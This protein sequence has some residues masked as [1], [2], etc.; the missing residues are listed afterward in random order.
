MER[1]NIITLRIVFPLGIINTFLY[2]QKSLYFYN[3][4]NITYTTLLRE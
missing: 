3:L 2:L 4:L 1:D